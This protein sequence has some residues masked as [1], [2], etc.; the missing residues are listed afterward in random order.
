MQVIDEVTKSKIGYGNCKRVVVD[1]T[2]T[3]DIIYGYTRQWKD[4]CFRARVFDRGGYS[5][6][7]WVMKTE[8]IKE[9]L[10]YSNYTGVWMLKVNI[11]QDVYIRETQRL[12]Q[13][14]FPYDFE[15][16]YEAIESFDIFNGRQEIREQR[17]Y[18]LSEFMRYTFGLEFETSAGLIPESV[19]MRDGLIPLR[20]GSISGLE[21]SSVVLEGNDGLNLLEQQLKTLKKYTV[22]NKECSLHI[23][24]GGYPLEADKVFR[25]YTVCRNLQN[26]IMNYVPELT[27]HT[28]QYKA[29]GKD[30]CKLLPDFGSFN[31]LYQGLVG[32][33]YLGD[34]TQPHPADP[35]RHHKWNIHTRYF[36][37][38]LVNL[39]C[40]RVNKTVEFRLLR[41][42]Y[43]FRKITLWLYIMNA[44]LR[45]SEDVNNP[46]NHAPN[47][48]Q[49]NDLNDYDKWMANLMNNQN[50]WPGGMMQNM[51]RQQ[52]RRRPAGPLTLMDVIKT[53]YPKDLADKLALELVKLETVVYNQKQSG[54]RIG[55]LTELEDKLFDSDEIL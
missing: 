49:K 40:Y 16:K 47:F 4:K 17:S 31:D 7:A 45:Y 26:D 25:L 19:V 53:V 20:D 50:G 48:N 11:P 9:N 23:H 10:F 6:E 51:Q 37:L 1:F 14:K 36:W 39:L 38:N 24:F 33:S 15:R 41:P 32:R 3:G 2:E 43:N 29:S 42:T 5:E 34:F 30:Y 13:N 28:A 52:Q 21:Y 18:P 44:I 12:G 54:D 27:F 35:D 22:F 55:A 46:I 8:K